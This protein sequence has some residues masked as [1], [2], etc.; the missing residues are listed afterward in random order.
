[1]RTTIAQ[2]GALGDP[3]GS[4]TR[5]TYW[6]RGVGP[7]ELQF[8]HDG[9]GYSPVTTAVLTSTNQTP[10]AV[11]PDTNY[12]PLV[13]GQTL[14]YRWT[15]KKHLREPE[16][17]KVTVGAVEN[18]TAQVKVTS[19]SGPMKVSGVY[20]YTT[21]LDGVTNIY[22]ST[23]A[24]SLV[25]FPKLA[26]K[27][28]FFTP[29]DFMNWGY[30]PIL[31]AYPQ[32]GNSWT[33]G[34]GRDFQIYGVKGTSYIVGIQKVKV[35]AGTFQALV[36][37]SVLKQPGHPFGSGTRISWFAPNRGLVKLVFDH[38]DGSVSTIELLK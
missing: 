9:G 3:Y 2:A 26:N 8:D 1:V 11:V 13:S 30:G 32:V 21:R 22:G 38:G 16:I 35:P 18:R 31:P 19:V 6:V 33:G 7:V 37:K 36:V 25:K 24:A 17:E 27:L 14:R 10:S 5:T 34:T 15:N 4:G 23:A 28:H 12:F 20:G 29:L